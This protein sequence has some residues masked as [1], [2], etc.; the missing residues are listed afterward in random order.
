F[1]QTLS[2]IS[3]WYK[4]TKSPLWRTCVPSVDIMD[5]RTF[6]HLRQTFLQNNLEPRRDIPNS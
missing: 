5:T 1:L 2:S 3:Q 6:K 4:L